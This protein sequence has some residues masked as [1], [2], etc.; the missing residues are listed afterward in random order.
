MKSDKELL[1]GLL[2]YFDNVM[3]DVEAGDSFDK[4]RLP[5]YSGHE[6]EFR[7]DMIVELFNGM[8]ETYARMRATLMKISKDGKPLHIGDNM[9]WINIIGDLEAYDKTYENNHLDK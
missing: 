2:T 7:I 8:M 1:Q 9:S 4:E 3:V 5:D 6:Q